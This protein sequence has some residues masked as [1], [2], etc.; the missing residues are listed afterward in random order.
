MLG[1]VHHATWLQRQ[2]SP[3]QRVHVHVHVCVCVCVCVWHSLDGLEEKHTT[4]DR[5]FGMRCPMHA[6]LLLC[7]QSTR[8]QAGTTQPRME[9]HDC[10]SRNTFISGKYSQALYRC[11]CQDGVSTRPDSTGTPMQ[12][13]KAPNGEG[14]N[15]TP[16]PA[17]YPPRVTCTRGRRTPPRSHPAK[18]NV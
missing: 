14:S 16:A 10:H 17:G 1:C 3:Q 18:R 11:Q 6:F 4:L 2:V 13:I 9:C 15:Q 8:H 7:G 12:L 5:E